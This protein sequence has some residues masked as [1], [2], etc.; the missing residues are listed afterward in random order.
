MAY[1]QDDYFAD[2]KMD[3]T[4]D[5]IDAVPLQST[6][7]IPRNFF[8]TGYSP[9]PVGMEP[10]LSP[11]NNC[12]P[13]ARSVGPPVPPRLERIVR[14]VSG[15][16][17]QSKMHGISHRPKMIPDIGA[18]QPTSYMNFEE[19]DDSDVKVPTANKTAGAHRPRVVPGIGAVR[20]PSNMKID[21]TDVSEIR[22]P[23]HTT[24]HA[25]Q[26]TSYGLPPRA[27]PKTSKQQSKQ[28]SSSKD[29]LK[30]DPL[31]H[32]A[33]V[34]PPCP[35]QHYEYKTPE[36]DRHYTHVSANLQSLEHFHPC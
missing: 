20:P 3:A 17:S 4:P 5:V 27:P 34:M 30:R 24:R 1:I 22:M 11:L 29:K 13:T 7:D 15:K 9:D 16:S 12:L 10:S 26:S 2:W 18:L 25:Q 35:I 31:L 21:Q 36:Q 32:K 8:V 14:E 23:P 28:E 19:P 33:L 6:P